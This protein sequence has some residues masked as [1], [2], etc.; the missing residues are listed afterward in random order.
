MLLHENVF[1]DNMQ[2]IHIKYNT[3]TYLKI[4]LQRENCALILCIKIFYNRHL[5][6][7]TYVLDISIFFAHCPQCMHGRQQQQ[8]RVH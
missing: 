1:N 5:Y 8:Q 2:Y 7:L 6:L 3:K 4:L